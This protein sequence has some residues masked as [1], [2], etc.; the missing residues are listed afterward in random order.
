GSIAI[1]TVLICVSACGG[2]PAE[3]GG[4]AAIGRAVIDAQAPPDVPSSD[5]AGPPDIASEHVEGDVL[6]DRAVGGNFDGGQIADA[7][8]VPCP[9]ITSWSRMRRRRFGRESTFRDSGQARS[10]SCGACN[11]TERGCSRLIF[12]KR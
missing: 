8:S 2:G 10:R 12:P 5:R 1:G 9:A 3:R 4:D 11:E 6:V 7:A